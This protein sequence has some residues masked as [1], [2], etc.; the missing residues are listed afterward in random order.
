MCLRNAQ[1]TGTLCCPLYCHFNIHAVLL[2]CRC[3]QYNWREM[4]ESDSLGKMTMDVLKIYLVYHKL[5]S[6]SGY[7]YYQ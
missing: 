1:R 3:L 2:N 5:K 7:T 4:R 6:V